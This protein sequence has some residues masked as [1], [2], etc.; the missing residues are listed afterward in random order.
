MSD[1]DIVYAEV[2]VLHGVAPGTT[3]T[4]ESLARHLPSRESLESARARFG[5][6]GFD[7]DYQAG[8]SFTISAPALHFDQVFGVRVEPAA[9]GG[10]QAQRD[11]RPLGG[12]LPLDRL[13]PRL[14]SLVHSVSFGEPIDFG[15]SDF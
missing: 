10:Y 14:R 1:E 8:A 15:P 6:L 5:D 3:I 7:V 9:G 12:D 2:L 11:G 4:A 13:D